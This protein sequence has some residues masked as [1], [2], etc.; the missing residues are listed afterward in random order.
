MAYFQEAENI[1]EYA[2]SCGKALN[3]ILITATL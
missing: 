3:K 2:G 1:L